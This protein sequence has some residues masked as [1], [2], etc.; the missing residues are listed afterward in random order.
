MY[1]IPNRNFNFILDQYVLESLDW[2]NLITKL[3]MYY[4]H[5]INI[6]LHVIVFDQSTM[7]HDGTALSELWHV[8]TEFQHIDY[9]NLKLQKHFKQDFLD[10][11]GQQNDTS[12]QAKKLI[13]TQLGLSADGIITNN[14]IL[15]EYR[16]KLTL[17]PEMIR[18]IPATDFWDICLVI[19]HGHNFFDID[20]YNNHPSLYYVMENDHGKHALNLFNTIAPKIKDHNAQE[21]IRNILLNRV[22]I[23]LHTRDILIFYDLQHD[24]FNRGNNKLDTLYYF[25]Y[26]HNYFFFL[27]WGLL[28][29]LAFLSNIIA[30]L[31]I[32]K[33]GIMRKD[34]S[35]KIESV[36]PLIH[37]H[38]TN[39]ENNAW[40][41]RI[42]HIRHP[43]SHRYFP[44]IVTVLDQESPVFQLSDDEVKK[45][46]LEE[47]PNLKDL[48]FFGLMSP[49]QLDQHLT[50][51]IDTWK[52]QH[53][54]IFLVK[55]A[56]VNTDETNKPYFFNPTIDV[57]HNLKKTIEFL[58]VFMEDI[59]N[60]LNVTR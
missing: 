28:E 5:G 52:A 54:D 11:L 56:L 23:L 14:A 12:E 48:P 16:Y 31:K 49:E 13:D 39:E 44:Q 38:I 25:Q 6:H 17:S 8:A 4:K 19:A 22:P 42:S 43:L 3:P 55:A 24:Y 20:E 41:E 30:D 34:F 32:D 26:F 21:T 37:K 2:K 53:A 57:D 46:I 35:K 1:Y 40:I 58:D 10:A 47:N 50:S 15:V 29:Q 59:N 60:Y 33:C 36:M 27:I 45:K 9:D 51:H 18:I 7:A